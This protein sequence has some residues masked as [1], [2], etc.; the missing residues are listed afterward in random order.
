MSERLT[1]HYNNEPIYDIV[2]SNNFDLLSEELNKL[3]VS[4]RKLC[5]VTETTVGPLYVEEIKNILSSLTNT[6]EIFTFE[7]GESNKNLDVVKSLYEFL[8]LKHFDRSDMLIALGGGVVGDLT[9]YAAATYL[10]GVDFVQIPTSL[11]S[12]VD[13]SVGGKTGVDFDSYKN[14]VGAFHQPKLVYSNISTLKTLTK[15]QFLSGMGEVVKAALIKDYDFYEWLKENFQKVKNYDEAA[16][17]HIV[18]T[19]CNIKRIVVENDFKEKGER[20]LLNFG[21]TL[22]HAIEK[23]MNFSLLHGECVSLG[24]VTAAH[25][26]AEKKYIT[27]DD[28]NDIID[29]IKLY[30]LPV[31]EKNFDNDKVL[32]A[33]KSD[34]KMRAGVI[35][36]V[37]LDKIGNAVIDKEVSIELMSGA[38]KI[39]KE[40]NK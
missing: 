12:Q 6:V 39:L 30:E 28:Y 9:G 14:M 35:N 8:I 29:T 38:L 3:N 31:F 23:L 24:M 34:K 7:A 10:R 17:T 26:S 33:T 18:L 15:R 36:F 11:L 1:V 37:L 16:L 25:I 21:H 2:I 32:E 40:A 5:I 4:K 13:S 22:G 27:I 19:S 20:A